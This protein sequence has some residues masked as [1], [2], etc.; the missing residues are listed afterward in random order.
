MVPAYHEKA[1][2]MCFD[3]C[4]AQSPPTDVLQSKNVIISLPIQG[5]QH[6]SIESFIYPLFKSWHAASGG[7]WTWD[8]IDSSY[9]VL[10]IPLW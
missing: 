4:A 2:N 7:M 9:F 3:C 1:I 6:Q 10:G 8:A 5:H